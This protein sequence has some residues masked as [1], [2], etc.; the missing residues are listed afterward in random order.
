MTA[1]FESSSYPAHIL[2]GVIGVSAVALAIWI[3]RTPEVGPVVGSLVL[4]G[5]AIIALRGY[6][7]PSSKSNVDFP[8]PEQPEIITN[9]SF[10]STANPCGIRFYARA[11]RTRMSER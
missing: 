10:A 9:I 1:I 2:C 7:S 6:P 5:I 4:G 8:P 11:R 3:G